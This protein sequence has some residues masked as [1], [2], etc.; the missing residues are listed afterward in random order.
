[1]PQPVRTVRFFIILAATIGTLVLAT[2]VAS[3]FSPTM[4]RELRTIELLG[5]VGLLAL[6]AATGLAIISEQR[7][8]G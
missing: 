6:P 5:L 7:A 8:R 2:I 4:F 1:M 3:A